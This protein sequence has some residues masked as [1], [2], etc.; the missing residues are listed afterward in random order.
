MKLVL[1]IGLILGAVCCLAMSV[2]PTP[3]RG[4]NKMACGA[5]CCKACS[6]GRPAKCTGCV[7]AASQGCGA[8]APV[9]IECPGGATFQNGNLTC[10]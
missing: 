2:A 6:E 10:N 3:Q 9:Y 7:T 1:S 8:G 4:L 5:W